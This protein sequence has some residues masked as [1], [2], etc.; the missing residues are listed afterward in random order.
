MPKTNKEFSTPTTDNPEWTAAKFARARRATDI[1]E[2]QGLLKRG[3]GPQIMP[4]KKMVSIRLSAD[5]A[6][7]LRASGRGW[8]SR[9]DGALRAWV[10]RK[11]SG[12]K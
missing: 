4:K 9:A 12:A 1:P 5:V 11:Q 6:D 3:R 10:E 7:A 2:L 8:Q